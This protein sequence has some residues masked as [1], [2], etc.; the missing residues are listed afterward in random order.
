MRLHH[1]CN[2]LDRHIKQNEFNIATMIL[3]ILQLIQKFHILTACCKMRLSCGIS[4]LLFTC[5]II[6]ANLQNTYD[7]LASKQLEKLVVS[8]VKFSSFGTTSNSEIQWI[9]FNAIYK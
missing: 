9:D 1:N 6:R 3:F 7:K 8:G 5:T 4:M 2:H